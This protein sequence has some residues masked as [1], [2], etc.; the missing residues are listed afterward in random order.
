MKIHLAGYSSDP[1][2]DPNYRPMERAV[3]GIN[4][5]FKVSFF[6]CRIKKLYIYIISFFFLLQHTLETVN[7]MKN[8]CANLAGSVSEKMELIGA[9][10]VNSNNEII[11]NNN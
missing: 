5:K 8:E 7:E 2:K 4:K 11:L 9:E 6:C 10:L 1:E 3:P